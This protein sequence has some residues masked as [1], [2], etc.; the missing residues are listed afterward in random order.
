MKP[1][2][3]TLLLCALAGGGSHSGP[4]AT[5]AAPSDATT[6]IVPG[7][8]GRSEGSV[9]SPDTLRK[10]TNIAYKGGEYLK[11]DVHWSFVTAGDA[12]L[13]VTDTVFAG[14]PCHI[15]TFRLESKPFFD[16]FYK[17]RDQYRTIVDAQGLFPWR[18]EQQIREGGFSRDFMAEFDQWENVAI[19]TAGTYPIPPYVQDIMSAF[20]FAR[21]VDYTG[22]RPGR[23]IELQNFYK[24]SVYPLAV[25]YK[26]RQRIEVDAGTFDC[27]IIEPLVTE[28]G[29]F[30]SKG[31]ILLWITDDDRKMPVKVRTEI[32][33]GTVEVDLTEFRG[34]YGPLRALIHDD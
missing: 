24:D 14:R 34:V 29:L 20:Y 25:K 27:I 19:T 3:S 7:A 23:R 9:P 8:P 30:K 32:P 16:I 17:V 21:T 11:F 13:T 26:G 22:F 5:D 4:P 15:V 6:R 28:G 18:F 31:R 12:Y 33:I 10:L 1:I 2:A